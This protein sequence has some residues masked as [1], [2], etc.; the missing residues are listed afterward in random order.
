MS[1][2]T[3]A[4]R[5]AL[6]QPVMSDA[7]ADIKQLLCDE[8]ALVDPTAQVRKTEYFNHTY[9][10]DVVL[11]WPD[12]EP[13]EVFVRFVA[14]PD[15]ILADSGLLGAKGPVFFDL[16]TAARPERAQD[17]IAATS[18][19][20]GQAAERSPRLLVT[21]TEAT[22]YIRPDA[23]QNLVERLVVSNVLRGGRGQL[24]ESRAKATVEAAR[25]GYEAAM[26]AEPDAVRAAVQAAREILDPD[27]ERRVERSL[28]LLWWVG[29]GAPEDF[30]ITVPDD[31]ELNPADTRDFL[32]LVFTD[33]P[34]IDD[35]AF[36]SRLADRLTFDTLVDVG[37]INQ[38]TNLNRL[39][40]QFAGRLKLSHAILRHRQ[41]P[42]PPDDQL[43]WGIEDRFLRLRGADWVCHF[44]P[45]GNRFSQRRD[46]GHS[47]SLAAADTRSTDYL[48]EE[49]EIDEAARQVVL[50]RK[51]V[52]PAGQRGRSLREL[53]AGFPDDASVRRITIRSGE[54]DLDVDFIRM[55]V[56]ADPDADVRRMA[57]IAVRLLAAI[58]EAGRNELATFLEA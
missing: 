53:A 44:T 1:E 32:R 36:W 48:V 55:L 35:D 23:S 22:A 30:P 41:R 21:D 49:A 39:M 37:H 29:G 16:A 50:S 10:P 14:S 45:Q 33:Q 57:T 4:V 51:A 56:G 8:L 24:D 20:A 27:I 43:A 13:R 25:G 54:S 52:D 7:T 58:D 40:R 17:E 11:D 12:R 3:D 28:Q 6:T 18:A 31:L 47:V 38:S 19:A 42:F 34:N 5:V 26:T 15:R 46:E 2:L 9:L